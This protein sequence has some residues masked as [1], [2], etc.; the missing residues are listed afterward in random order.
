M[1]QFSFDKVIYKLIT[2]LVILISPVC[3]DAQTDFQT[4]NALWFFGEHTGIRWVFPNG[5]GLPLPEV[6][7][8]S[9]IAGG[10]IESAVLNQI[11][12]GRPEVE[13]S[14][15]GYR[16]YRANGDIIGHSSF[17]GSNVLQIGFDSWWR[18]E[19]SSIAAI[20]PSPG[21]DSLYYSIGCELRE[22]DA[23]ETE[24]SMMKI[25][26][27]PE[28]GVFDWRAFGTG[29]NRV[30]HHLTEGFATV[31]G[32]CGNLWAISHYGIVS[33]SS[34]Y[35]NI[36]NGGGPRYF[37]RHDR[38][39]YIATTVNRVPYETATSTSRAD[40]NLVV[41]VDNLRALRAEPIITEFGPDFSTW[42]HM[43]GKIR[44][45][46]DYDKM[47]HTSLYGY[48]F[49][50]KFDNASGKFYDYIELDT[51]A[52]NPYGAC[53]APN[54]R[55]VY[56]T[57][58]DSLGVDSYL[59]TIYQYDVATWEL[60]AIRD[61]KMAIAT[62]PNSVP[63]VNMQITPD[64]RIFIGR[65]G[66]NYLSSIEQP[67]KMGLDCEFKE[68]GFDLG[69]HIY[70]GPALHNNMV[71]AYEY[72]PDIDWQIL[73]EDT[74]ICAGTVLDLTPESGNTACLWGTAPF[75][76]FHEDP[77]YAHTVQNVA[78][79]D[80]GAYWVRALQ[81]GVCLVTDTVQ[82]HLLDNP[83]PDL[84]VDTT[85]CIGDTVSLALQ[86][87]LMDVILTWSDGSNDIE[88]DVTDPG[89]YWID[90]SSSIGNCEASDSIRVS[91]ND[92]AIPD[93]G[94]DTS[95]C[96]GNLLTLEPDIS[97]ATLE[98]YDGTTSGSL[99][100]SQPGNYWVEA[101]KDGCKAK[102][103][104]QVFE[105]PLPIVDIGPDT[106]LCMGSTVNV[107]SSA[108]QGAEYLWQ[109]GSDASSVVASEPGMYWLQVTE[110]GCSSVDSMVLAI[111]DHTL[112]VILG[113]QTLC[114]GDT[115][116]L[117]I[118]NTYDQV[119]WQGTAMDSIVI[120]VGPVS[121]SVE[122]DDCAYEDEIIISEISLPKINLGA[123]TID[124][125]DAPLELSV[126]DVMG[127][128]IEWQDGTLSDTYEVKSPGIYSVTVSEENCQ[129][130]DSIQILLPETDCDCT[131]YLPNILSTNIIEESSFRPE[132]SCDLDFYELTIMDRWGN[133]IFRTG[134]SDEVFNPE[135]ENLG[136]G[137]YTYK[138][139]YQFF[140]K[141]RKQ[142]F[143]TLTAF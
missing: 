137:V 125:L 73:P 57:E 71:R 88:L 126:G 56:V 121:V 61:S 25:V 11:V 44:T 136:T 107:M 93:L 114:P 80:S 27:H 7:D 3:L 139:E 69:N 17:T 34:T 83:V 101:E 26:K 104:I 118:N 35:I 97:G 76:Q 67:D 22:D 127:F 64:Q 103:S 99:T 134:N 48:V 36:P 131:F 8:Y 58:S 81:D 20:I 40:Y 117:S 129:V 122:I 95:F 70:D 33:D 23:K 123:D 132:T 140:N 84:G 43:R 106:T 62:F 9:P 45:S 16:T 113:D 119:V 28:T 82:V 1:E 141:D 68:M 49:F 94:I 31:P 142:T 21:I 87:S 79:R 39:Q 124:C 110:D 18:A 15:N 53:F 65:Q 135:N 66:K 100:I 102:D 116:T 12:N 37:Y 78:I 112:P 5:G 111:Y 128:E 19:L 96:E 47:V 51:L 143:G 2:G 120:S 86:E 29:K 13:I 14:T 77:F 98:W 30:D 63:H 91:F 74:T 90:A 52:S 60:D 108:S 6:V 38:N 55:Y 75:D 72:E 92:A 115:I 10:I 138:I 50:L 109:D 41:G 130:K 59:T 89:T 46:Y 133:A 54:N 24:A 4:D 85:L 105:T 32:T 42:K